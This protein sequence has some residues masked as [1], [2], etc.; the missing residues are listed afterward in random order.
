MLTR[1]TYRIIT[2]FIITSVLFAVTSFL[3]A[4]SRSH[5]DIHIHPSIPKAARIF[6]AS[7][8]GPTQPSPK[9]KD[10]WAKWSRIFYDSRPTI[11]PIVVHSPASVEGSDQANGE[12]QPSAHTLNL[13][14][15]VISSLYDSHKA[16]LL[17]RGGLY[18]SDLNNVSADLFSGTGIVTV[19]GGA[20]FAPAIVSIRMLRR[21][22]NLP[23]HIFIA[24]HTEY[25]PELCERVF[26][27][28]NAEC[29]TMSDFLAQD[30]V[31]V[32]HFQLKALAILFSSFETILYLDSDCFAVRDP[33]EI[34]SSEPFESTGLVTWPD[35]WKATED[36][37]FYNIA[38]MSNFPLG[39]PARS[40]E[41][42]ELLISKSKHLSSLLL[43][44]YYNIYG[45]QY[46]YPILS[47]GAAG[48]GDKE[49]FLAAAVVL[50]LPYY[51]VREHVGTI[52]YF[53]EEGE[54][55]G[56]A[57]VQYHP[58]DDLSVHNGTWPTEQKSNTV[59]PFFLHAHLPKLNVGRML[60][61]STLTSPA[62]QALRLWGDKEGI[63]K[64]FEGRD[65]EKEVWQEMKD[66]TCALEGVM[67]D[68]RER[69]NLCTRVKEHYLSLFGEGSWLSGIM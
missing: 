29:F 34:L 24:D 58:G 55:K 56:G 39:L 31:D 12:R 10:F 13:P 43:A 1:L 18:D 60:D 35:Y 66:T 37:V 4:W 21:V 38:G 19:A 22:S 44:C 40:T 7:R 3:Q 49:T 16:L 68:W 48:E 65:M 2:I 59:R 47:Q 20:Y 67:K 53:T 25:E 41:S 27:A 14:Q 64:L 15:T 63:Q 46:Y 6:S 45:P 50:G 17:D 9:I 54:F 57:M 61:E 69:H 32:T 11:D 36:P 23:V 51:R 28:L 33:L 52:G 5:T 8:H 42:G 26:P 62:G 30:S